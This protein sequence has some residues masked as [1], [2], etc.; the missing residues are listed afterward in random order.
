MTNQSIRRTF[1]AIHKIGEV[2]KQ[3]DIFGLVDANNITYHFVYLDENNVLK[4]TEQF[5]A[6]TRL[7]LYEHIGE[8]CDEHKNY[9]FMYYKADR[10][11][12]ED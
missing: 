10:D 7:R 3:L 5:T 11:L 12:W 8:W 6:P 2:M 4:R 9:R 1:R